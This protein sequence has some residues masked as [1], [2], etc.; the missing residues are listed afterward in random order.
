MADILYFIS[1]TY[2]LS[3]IILA[4]FR[5]YGF[6]SRQRVRKIVSNRL[7]FSDYRLSADLA[8]SDYVT[9]H[10]KKDDISNVLKQL[11]SRALQNKNVDIE[12]LG[13]ISRYTICNFIIDQNET[14]KA[15]TEFENKNDEFREINFAMINALKSQKFR[16]RNISSKIDLPPPKNANLARRT[17]IKLSQRLTVWR[18][19]RFMD[20]FEKMFRRERSDSTYPHFSFDVTN[21]ESVNKEIDMHAA[22]SVDMKIKQNED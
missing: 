5:A 22:G 6:F 7:L 3:A 16:D 20:D 14:F 8:S 4:G 15:L 1:T 12:E 9:R 17:I 11:S 21:I 13:E 19:N 10:Q 2:L 18:L